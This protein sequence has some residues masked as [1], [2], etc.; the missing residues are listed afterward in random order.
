MCESS[1]STITSIIHRGLSKRGSE[2]SHMKEALEEIGQIEVAYLGRYI[3]L[4]GTIA[5]IAP[6]MGLLGTVIGMID[7]FRAVVNEVGAQGGMVNPAS[8]ASGIWAALIT[9]AA[10]LSAAIPAYLGYKYLMGYIDRIAVELEEVGLSLLEAVYPN[11]IKSETSHGQVDENLE[12]KDL[13]TIPS[14]QQAPS[15]TWKSVRAQTMNFRAGLK[16]KPSAVLDMTPLVDVVF[17]LLIFFLLTSTYVQ[18]SQ[19]SSSSVPVELPESSLEASPNSPE[20]IVISIDERGLVYIK[21]EEISLDQL[22]ASLQRVAK[23]KPNTIVLVRGDQKVPYGRVGQV[24][25]LVRASGLNLSA[26]L[27][28]GQ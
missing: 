18:Q 26:V 10:G 28:S 5:T 8:L 9:T 21:D 1:R 23:N 17:Q 12:S 3:E 16:K 19:Q 14:S 7:V 15:T 27:Q 25:S 22:A 11:P 20:E 24:M 4:L 2:R 13:E 6:L